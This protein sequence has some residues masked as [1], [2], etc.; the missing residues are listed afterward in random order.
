MRKILY[1]MRHGQTLFN[2]RRKVQGFCD[3]P[4]TEEG[5]R[6]AKVAGEYFK[7]IE[8]DHYYSSTQE[9][10]CDTLEIITDN[11]VPYVRLKGLK[12]MNFGK[13]EGES[14][15]LNPKGPR[16]Y[17]TFFIPYGGESS[18]DVRDRMVETCTEIMEK[19]DH[20]VVLAVSHGGACFNFLKAWQDPTE[21]LK[22][23]FPNCSI[24]KFEYEDKKF[25]LLEVI[26]PEV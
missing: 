12:E 7:D 2:A 16:E 14:E 8:I 13:F 22:K 26:R 23:G 11:K 6:Q 15:D 19:E 21:E 9:R 5:I 4:L 10:A 17:E 20:K 1:L 3:S 25:K 24:F 18:N